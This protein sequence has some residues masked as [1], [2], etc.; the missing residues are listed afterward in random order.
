MKS[1][2]DVDLRRLK[3]DIMAG[4]VARTLTRKYQI[5]KETLARLVSALVESG[6]LKHDDLH[7]LYSSSEILRVLTWQCRYCRKIVPAAYDKCPR[8]GNSR[9]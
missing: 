4:L 1:T 3:S 5:S 6:D 9:S 8:C 7:K 2:P